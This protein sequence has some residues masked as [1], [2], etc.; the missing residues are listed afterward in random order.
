MRTHALIALRFG[1]WL[2]VTGE[3]PWCPCWEMHYH[4]ID[5]DTNEVDRSDFWV[6]EP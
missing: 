1:D 2:E 5:P 4:W 6:P 3:C